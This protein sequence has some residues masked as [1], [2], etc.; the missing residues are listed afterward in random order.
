MTYIRAWKS[1]KFGQIR[2]LT[3]ELAGLE[4]QKKSPPTYNGEK[5]IA[6]FSWLFLIESFSYLQ[7]TITYIRTW[8]SLKFGQIC[9]WTTELAALERL[10]NQCYHFLS[11]A[12]YPI[13]FKFVGIKDIHNI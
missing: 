10:K 4:L 3:K 13:H 11:V 8:M 7:V 9:P 5:G 2:P 12:F 6:T 1:S